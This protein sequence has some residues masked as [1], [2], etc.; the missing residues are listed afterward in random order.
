MKNHQMLKT[1]KCFGVIKLTKFH[2]RTAKQIDNLIRYREVILKWMALGKTVLSTRRCCWQDKSESSM[3]DYMKV[4]DMVAHFWVLE[5][6]EMLD[7]WNAWNIHNTT[8]SYTTQ[9]Q[10][11]IQLGRKKE[12]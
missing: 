11:K 4:Y 2:E 3:V 8:N 9:S 10:G 12:N 7:I 6:L 5:S 1:V